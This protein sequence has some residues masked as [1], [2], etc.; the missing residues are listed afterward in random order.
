MKSEKDLYRERVNEALSVDPGVTVTLGN[1]EYTLEFNNRAIKDLLKA[2]G[3]NI[4]QQG[5]GKD[6]L[7]DPEFLTTFLLIGLKLHH[8][9]CT[10]EEVDRVFNIR[11]YAYVVD[12][13]LQ[14]I[15]MFSPDMSDIQPSGKVEETP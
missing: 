3:L 12:K 14:A 13:L 11:H 6:R 2:T 1:K 10:E 7:G 4:L 15:D 5:I 9:D 8:P